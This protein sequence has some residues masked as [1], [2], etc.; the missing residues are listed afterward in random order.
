MGQT[1]KKP[2]QQLPKMAT[3]LGPAIRGRRGRA[4][5]LEADGGLKLGKGA[6]FVKSRLRRLPQT[7]DVWEAGFGAMPNRLGGGWLGVVVSVTNG[8][9]FADRVVESAPTVN[10]LAK[11]VADAMRRL[12]V[13]EAHRPRSIRLHPMP[14]WNELIPHLEELGIEV[15]TQKSL[16]KCEEE[17]TIFI[18]E[19]LGQK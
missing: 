5:Q 17:I 15:V 9:I 4:D 7:D 1:S 12:F 11:L 10:D 6:A 3:P 16:P 14:E 13:E 19:V 8:Y 18:K 2:H